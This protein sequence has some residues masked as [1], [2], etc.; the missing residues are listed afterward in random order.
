MSEATARFRDLLGEYFDLQASAALLSWDQN[1]YM[2]PG[3][4]E[5]R[6]MQLSTLSR[7]A[8]EHFT[9][10]AFGDGLSA[11]EAATAG[12]PPDSDELCIARRIRREYD[13]QRRVPT[14]WVGEHSRVTAM[15]FQVWQDA[16]KRS[17]FAS[18]RPHLARVVELKKQYS[19][20][21]A[22]YDHI[23]DPLL[24]DYEP[25]MKTAEVEAVFSALRPK[26]TA[27]IRAIADR[28]R[29]VDDSILHV[30]YE[31][32]KQ[33][34]FGLSVIKDFGFDFERGRQDKA[35]HP[36]TTG[37]G[38]GD[39]RIT[40]RIQPAFFNDCFFSTLHEGGHAMYAQG[41]SPT[42]DRTPLIDG[43]SLA[44]HES[45]SRMWENIVGRSLPFWRY[46][47]PRLQATFPAQL[48]DV[49]LEDFHRAINKVQPSF[50]RTEA[51][52]ATYNLHVM[53]RFELELAL[54]QGDL[55]PDELPD[56]WNEK[57][58]E[59]L[60]ITPPNDAQGVLQDVHWS[61]GLI[62][63]FSTYALGNLIAC[64]LWEKIRQDI[65]DIDTQIEQAHFGNLLGWLRRTIHQH[66]AKFEPMDLL[67]RAVG[68]G[69][70]PA[71]YMRYLEEKCGAIYGL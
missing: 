61:S 40:T 36:F 4:A 37:F 1:T 44:I 66:G 22:P 30:E 65:P 55:K 31:E 43:A 47:Y 28:G 6:S 5:A 24:D 58:R 51:D 17:D 3:G 32:D 68:T 18:F 11:A 33:W 71:P 48:G 45:Q 70:D 10:E 35:P 34:A 9:S 49:P 14:D 67:E 64:Q 26:Q 25:G 41:V 53:L 57:M 27:L 19:S 62:G 46:Y 21:F 38:I 7:L 12:E 8:H 52:E 54:I 29:Q 56:I 50:I 2:P 63:Y 42:L 39:V 59:Y 69:L 16:R 15:A 60:G 13:K 23:Y 20:F